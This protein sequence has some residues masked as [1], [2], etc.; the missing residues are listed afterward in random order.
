MAEL[1]VRV[2]NAGSPEM[3]AEF[4]GTDEDG[5][6]DGSGQADGAGYA[7]MHPSGGKRLARD[8]V[9][10]RVD[11]GVAVDEP[12][13]GDVIGIDVAL[14]PLQPLRPVA[15]RVAEK[16]VAIG[17]P[18]EGLIRVGEIAGEGMQRRC[19]GKTEERSHRDGP[20]ARSAVLPLHLRCMPS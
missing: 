16:T 12:A 20:A 4:G 15:I 11:D 3:A 19:S 9:V 8:T 17:W 6:A 18:S 13:V 2:Q 7:A 1:F 5:A 10:C 14:R